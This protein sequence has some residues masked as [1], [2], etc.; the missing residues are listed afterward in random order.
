MTPWNKEPVEARTLSKAWMALYT[1]KATPGTTGK[2]GGVSSGY[3]PNGAKQF[4]L[5]VDQVLD[6]IMQLPN[7]SRCE[8][9]AA[10]PDNVLTPQLLPLTI[11][12]Q[13]Q[14][15]A[16]EAA[17]SR[18]PEDVQGIIAE[19]T[20][21]G[22]C[23]VCLEEEE[24][25]DDL[26]LQCDGC[27]IFT[28]MSCYG[29]RE[30]PKGQ[31]W[32]CDTCKV[33]AR[34]PPACN[35]CP[36]LG[37]ALKRTDCGRWVHPSCVMWLPEA[38]YLNHD[39]SFHCLQG[40]VTGLS[41]VSSS[42]RR[43]TCQICRQPHGACM[44]C[45]SPNCFASFHIMCARQAGYT[46]QLEADFDDSSDEED[47]LEMELERKEPEKLQILE[48]SISTDPLLPQ[49]GNKVEIQVAPEIVAEIVAGVA[50][51]LPSGG[52]REFS[53]TA[54]LTNTGDSSIAG[55]S[56]SNNAVLTAAVAT[57]EETPNDVE[58]GALELELEQQQDE[59]MVEIAIIDSGRLSSG[60]G[61]P[62][63]DENAVAAANGPDLPVPDRPFGK[64]KGA[65]KQTVGA[66]ST[67]AP[68]P[69]APPAALPAKEKKAAGKKKPAAK[70]K[71]R[72]E[73][74][75]INGARLLVFC[76]KHAPPNSQLSSFK[77][78]VQ[79]HLRSK[80]GLPSKPANCPLV[81]G[82]GGGASGHPQEQQLL[83][84]SPGDATATVADRKRS[85]I[86]AAAAGGW[87]V[88]GHPTPW[89]T[90]RAIP[91]DGALRRGP[92]APEAIEA[93]L[94]KRLYIQ[95][96]PLLLGGPSPS[97]IPSFIKEKNPT[98]CCLVEEESIPKSVC[99][100]HPRP[101]PKD[102]SIV[103]LY[104]DISQPMQISEDEDDD[105]VI[106]DNPVRDQTKISPMSH[107]SM[108][109]QQPQEQVVV[110]APSER[111]FPVGVRDTL[112]SEEENSDDPVGKDFC[113][114]MEQPP[115]VQALPPSS[116]LPP[117]EARENAEKIA[118][119]RDTSVVPAIENIAACAS[120]IGDVALVGNNPIIIKNT[121]KDTTHNSSF[122]EDN[123]IDAVD[124]SSG[125]DDDVLIVATAPM[126]TSRST[127]SS[128]TEKYS[129]MCATLALRVVPGKSAIHG[130]GAFAKLP[131]SKGKN[132]NSGIF[133]KGFF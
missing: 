20:Q 64:E 38:T 84:S 120:T 127:L 47:M 26:V 93:A 42:R 19:E 11:E 74:T 133:F 13:R 22:M 43:L 119:I 52:E 55:I 104:M 126:V 83:G 81:G 128:V 57:K 39:A 72:L 23:Y 60:S 110:P 107:H 114:G 41:S 34:R 85:V 18:L 27:G 130:W 15:L 9:F 6:A 50:E 69:V 28:H 46:L 10:W 29:V 95:A 45:C 12:E 44:Q 25:D 53:N 16:Y 36:I 5:T 131:H 1:P 2:G 79:Q 70:N 117:V 73:G 132:L 105:V 89:P 17:S 96:T 7:A 121:D 4:G 76:S 56:V 99:T 66:M 62:S 100:V 67:G 122:V 103:A 80:D 65:N 106:I 33:G 86:A 88:P 97:L 113:I 14:R 63:G 3:T 90:A 24:D 51:G 112:P 32:L 123:S 30:H 54:I 111:K 102:S 35:L 77:H 78:Q 116:P 109:Q 21:P 58:G 118:A 129:E 91:L 61:T 48:E 94:A 87:P 82:G 8:K 125:I 71:K 68:A 49:L 59:E 92:R 115:I 75:K 98:G 31:L 108:P 37:G 40:L 101:A 124:D